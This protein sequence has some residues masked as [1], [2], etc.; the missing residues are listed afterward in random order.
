VFFH[1]AENFDAGSRE[2]L[3]KDFF[4]CPSKTSQQHGQDTFI[5]HVASCVHERLT[6]RKAHDASQG[7]LKLLLK[8][9]R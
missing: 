8:D 9:Q 2:R 3:L 7:F 1:H 4:K 5:K 6:I